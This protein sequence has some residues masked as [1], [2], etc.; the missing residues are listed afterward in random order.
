MPTKSGFSYEANCAKMVLSLVP[1]VLP[2]GTS[3]S[4]D[5][6]PQVVEPA[7]SLST[8][9]SSNRL[10]SSDIPLEITGNRHEPG[11]THRRDL[12]LPIFPYRQACTQ[13]LLYPEYPRSPNQEHYYIELVV[14]VP[15]KRWPLHKMRPYL[16]EG[17]PVAHCWQQNPDLVKSG[18]IICFRGEH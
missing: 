12:C 14:L 1:P 6:S 9:N 5:I 8:K 4:D 16:E 15:P 17:L 3:K 2:S 13:P 7:V 11:I 10:L 18:V